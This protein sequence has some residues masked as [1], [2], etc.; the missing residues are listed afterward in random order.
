[1]KIDLSTKEGYDIATGLT[2]HGVS[3]Y[4]M[5]KK[6]V[7]GAIR[8]KTGLADTSE[9]VIR[10]KSLPTG[11][12][13][14][15]CCLELPHLAGASNEIK[16][17]MCHWAFHSWQAAKALRMDSNFVNFIF[18]LWVTLDWGDY[19]IIKQDG[20]LVESDIIYQWICQLAEAADKEIFK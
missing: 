4:P 12:I 14:K 7:T 15:L 10:T 13:S 9:L 18:S 8:H 16:S 19:C 6:L 1:M 3:H 11:E 5:L 20:V 17:V 2:G